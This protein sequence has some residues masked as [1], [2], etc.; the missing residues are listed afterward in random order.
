MA[1]GKVG[2]ARPGTSLPEPPRP[3]L[4]PPG[5]D[6]SG[7]SP[8]R[9]SSSRGASGEPGEVI[10]GLRGARPPPARFLVAT[11]ETRAGLSAPLGQP[12]PPGGAG[13]VGRAAEASAAPAPP[14]FA[15]AELRPGASPA[16]RPR[17]AAPRPPRA[18]PGPD[19]PPRR[20]GSHSPPNS[21]LASPAAARLG[22]APPTRPARSPGQPRLQR[23]AWRPT[24]GA[25]AA[26]SWRWHCRGHL[27]AVPPTLPHAT[28]R[29]AGDSPEAALLACGQGPPLP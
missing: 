27:C 5:A 11:A 7:Y 20:R 26:R 17:P 4:A 25:S 15:D 28:V 18:A 3:S 16:V 8:C 9:E 10:P 22:S 12:G 2:L 24:R 21:R 19:G 1:P 29:A 13:T 6:G 23:D 14:R